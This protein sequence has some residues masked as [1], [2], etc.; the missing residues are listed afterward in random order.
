MCVYAMLCLSHHRN[1]IA[2]A[3]AL[4]CSTCEAETAPGRLK[5][6]HALLERGLHQGHPA[7]GVFGHYPQAVRRSPRQLAQLVLWACRGSQEVRRQA[8]REE[9]SLTRLAT[10]HEIIQP[11]HTDIKG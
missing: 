1:T 3:C 5:A 2:A 4:L 10:L 7:A 6:E 9:A 11:A 8:G